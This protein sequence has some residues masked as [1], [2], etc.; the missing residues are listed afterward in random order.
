MT[1]DIARLQRTIEKLQILIDAAEKQRVGALERN[2]KAAVGAAQKLLDGYRYDLGIAHKEIDFI[3][4][5]HR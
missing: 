3:L 4:T 1:A 5:T 2:D